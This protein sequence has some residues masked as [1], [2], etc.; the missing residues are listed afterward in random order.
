MNDVVLCE[1]KRAVAL[2][3]AG[4]KL[5]VHVSSHWSLVTDAAWK[6]GQI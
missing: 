1:C 2:F 3:M 6:R 5:R 4:I